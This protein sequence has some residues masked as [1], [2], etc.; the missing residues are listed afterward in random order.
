[1]VTP[2]CANAR[3]T[4]VGA[5]TQLRADATVEGDGGR[6]IVWSDE[7]TRAYGNISARGGPL[8]GDGGFV[9]TSSHSFLSVLNAPD[10]AAPL[11]RGGTWLL[12]PYDITVDGWSELEPEPGLLS[13]NFHGGRRQL[14][15]EQ[16]RRSGTR[17]TPAESSS[18]TPAEPAEA[19]RPATSRS[20]R[21]SR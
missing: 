5:D 11:G 3:A 7:V 14:D 8:G 16:R 9:E 20:M 2:T 17:S 12:D 4:F 1:M 19:R 6:I 13:P 21:R 10:I 18:S 15:G